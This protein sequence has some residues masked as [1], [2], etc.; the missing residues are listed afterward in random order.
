MS[1]VAV[2]SRL[3]QFINA[4]FANTICMYGAVEQSVTRDTEHLFDVLHVTR[5]NGLIIE[6]NTPERYTHERHYHYNI[7]ELIRKTL[8]YTQ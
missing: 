2:G 5:S 4:I 8:F 7:V 3:D 6:I 1:V